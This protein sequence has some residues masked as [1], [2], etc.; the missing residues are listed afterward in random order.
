MNLEEKT[1]DQLKQEW[2]QEL[3]QAEDKSAAIMK[4]MEEYAEAANSNVIAEIKSEAEKSESDRDYAQRMDLR[5]LSKKEK[6]FYEKIKDVKQAVTGNQIDIIPNSIIDLT[7]ADIRESNTLLS[8]I[9]FSPADV[10]RWYVASKNG[11]YAWAKL[12]AALERSK[13]IAATFESILTELGKFYILII[14]PKSIRDL[15]LPF[16][17][18]YF[19]AVLKEQEEAGLT[20]GFL[21]GNGV[22][23]PIGI[24]NQ[25]DAVDE[26]TKA[27]KPKTLNTNL[28]C[29]TPKGL[30]SAKK[31]LTNDGKRS[32][33]KF[34]LICNPAD[35]ADYV[36]PALF[37][38]QGNMISSYKNLEVIDTPENAK[39][40]AALYLDKTYTMGYSGVK[41]KDY[42]QTL[43]LEDADILIGTGYANGRAID[44]NCA[45][46]FDV[47]KLEEYI[48]V[49][50]TITSEVQTASVE[51]VEEA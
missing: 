20:Y 11:S 27:N 51:E 46:V 19:R 6:D 13:D 12:T 3:E 43:A 49:I 28:T 16:I 15:S 34:I 21:E 26:A 44:D 10:K 45:Y 37:D 39:G 5:P 36:D 40:K 38:A 4:V 22:E 8:H 2:I 42:D 50:R 33:S 35:R 47:T 7:L 17:D 41:V 29:F 32:L 18:K 9:N 14:I 1:M 48:P 30:A 31:H 24:Y 25:I 23:Q